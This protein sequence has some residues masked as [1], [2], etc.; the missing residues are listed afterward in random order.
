MPSNCIFCTN[1]NQYR[2]ST[3][4]ITNRLGAAYKNYKSCKVNPFF[5]S[6]IS[7]CLSNSIYI[8]EKK[9]TVPMAFSGSSAAYKLNYT[10]YCYFRYYFRRCFHRYFR[11]YFFLYF[12]PSYTPR[13]NLAA[14]ACINIA[15]ACYSPPY[16]GP[17]RY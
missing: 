7:Y 10:F 16:Y 6:F 15:T 4:F 11:R 2:S 13:V 1:C 8:G 17:V 9:L 14:I 3:D 5:Y 12:P